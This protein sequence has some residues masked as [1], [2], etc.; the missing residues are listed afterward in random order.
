MNDQAYSYPETTYSPFWSC[1]IV[2]VAILAAN[3][4]QFFALNEEKAN[5]KNA[6]TNIETASQRVRL[7]EAQLESLARDL[8]DLSKNNATAR[9]IV[10]EFNIQVNQPDQP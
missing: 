9:E 10:K 5:L 3:L 6:R 8:I 2:F 4:L 7:A 1:A